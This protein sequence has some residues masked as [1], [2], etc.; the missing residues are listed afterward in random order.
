VGLCLS[1]KKDYEILIGEDIKIRFKRVCS[2]TNQMMIDAP[3]DIKIKLNKLES[4]ATKVVK[5]ASTLKKQ[6]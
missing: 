4:T 2:G 3:K 6:V 1:V 5:S